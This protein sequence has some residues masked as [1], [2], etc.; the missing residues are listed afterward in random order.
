[1]HTLNLPKYSL[2]LKKEGDKHFIFDSIRK[3]YLVL[4][5]E[6]W[7]RQNFVEF[8]IQEKGYPKSLIAIEMGIEVNGRKKRCDIVLYNNTGKP[9]II[10]E[11]KAPSIKISQD[12]FDQ[13]ARYNMTLETDILIVSNGLNHFVCKMNHQDQCYNFLKE[14]PHY[15]EL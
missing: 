3:K 7:V 9:Q 1:M 5:P 8:L 14:T 13:I 4:T 12:A 2:K 6:E 15:S 11:C 10:V